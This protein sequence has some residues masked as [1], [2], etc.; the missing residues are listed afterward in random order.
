LR[1]IIPGSSAMVN[2]SDHVSALSFEIF[3]WMRDVDHVS[4]KRTT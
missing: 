4:P 2:A 1:T 3:A